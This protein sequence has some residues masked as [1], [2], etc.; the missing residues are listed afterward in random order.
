LKNRLRIVA[1]LRSYALGAL[2]EQFLP[3]DRDGGRSRDAQSGY[4]A[5]DRDHH[6]ANV[7]GDHNFFAD[8]SSQD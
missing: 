6:H 7:P 4:P 1:P 5:F 8:T 3:D 2:R